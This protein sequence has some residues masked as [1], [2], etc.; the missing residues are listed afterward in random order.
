MGRGHLSALAPL[1]ERIESPW[2]RQWRAASRGERNEPVR[3]EQ[4]TQE[5][6]RGSSAHPRAKVAGIQTKKGWPLP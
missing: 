6:I 2:V 1:I 4:P 5:E 3:V